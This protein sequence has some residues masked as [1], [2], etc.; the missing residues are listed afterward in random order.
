MR[1]TLLLVG[2]IFVV[3]GFCAATASGD[4]F[5]LVSTDVGPDRITA[6]TFL[7]DGFGCGGGNESPALSWSGA[8]AGTKS[9]ALSIYDPDAP[10]RGWWHWYVID[11]P[12]GITSLPRG[13]GEVNGSHLPEGAWQI[14]NDFGTRDYGGPCPPPGDRPHRYIVTVYTLNVKKLDLPADAGVALVD[15]KVKASAL[16][17][18]NLTF[19]YGR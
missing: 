4:E 11:L 5:K 17:R 3:S 14:K 9:Y 7:F 16:G 1:Y 12:A 13:A 18:A 10:G 19:K 6:R 2:A 8:P 15:A